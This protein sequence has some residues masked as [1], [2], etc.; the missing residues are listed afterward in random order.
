MVK[1][2]QL[3]PKKTRF[4]EKP[5]LSIIIPTLNEEKIIGVILEKIRKAAP[6]GVEII[7][8]DGRSHDHTVEIALKHGARVVFEGRG[9]PSIGSGRNAGAKVARADL[10]LFNDADTAPDPRFFDIVRKDF[11]DERVVGIGCKVMPDESGA[12]TRAFF[13]FLNFLV[14][15]SVWVGRPSI[16]GNCVA[17]RKKQFWQ[18]KGFDEEM[19][20]SEDQDLCIRI[21]KL[22]KVVYHH[23]I[24]AVTSSRRL[25]KFGL[26]GLIIDWGR[27]TINFLLGRKTKRY[28][29][30]REV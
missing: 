16:A 26:F 5:W 27:T 4:P 21:S 19:Q 17:Y 23:G 10:F 29:I 7:V 11:Q 14:R 22:G 8:A 24:V 2:R 6:A 15:F 1:L 18:I 20:A 9:F 12:L 28:A 30:I 25:K 3:F 13:S